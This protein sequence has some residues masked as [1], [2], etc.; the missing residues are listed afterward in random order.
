[1]DRNGRMKLCLD[2][3]S[4][5]QCG[6]RSAGLATE[7]RPARSLGLWLLCMPDLKASLQNGWARA[8][9]CRTGFP[10]AANR[11][12]GELVIFLDLPPRYH[13]HATAGVQ[14]SR[15]TGDFTRTAIK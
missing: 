9:H 5:K 10:H 15:R 13:Q 7:T 4:R 2:G 1:M 6:L 11:L 8:S 12:V 14:S 3:L